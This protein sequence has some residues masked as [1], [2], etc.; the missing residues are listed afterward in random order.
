[1]NGA[2]FEGDILNV[3]DPRMIGLDLT[4]SEAALLDCLPVVLHGPTH[5]KLFGLG[6]HGPTVTGAASSTR[7][8][9]RLFASCP[10][11]GLNSPATCAT[12]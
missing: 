11:A 7:F 5:A 10:A 12:R 1:M 9:S 3:A 4:R 8:M 2:T 6:I